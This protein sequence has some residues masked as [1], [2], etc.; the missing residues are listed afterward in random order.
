[1][2]VHLKNPLISILK[3]PGNIKTEFDKGILQTDDLTIIE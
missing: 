2:S 1:M 3:V